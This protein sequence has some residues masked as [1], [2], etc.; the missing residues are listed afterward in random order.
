MKVRYQNL[1]II[2]AQI[3]KLDNDYEEYTK[4]QANL[5]FSTR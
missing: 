4:A 2:K 5:K 3:E 1:M